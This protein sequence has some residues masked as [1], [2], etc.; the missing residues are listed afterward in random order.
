V[1]LEATFRE[2][3]VS[4]HQLHD[5]LDALNVTLGD[6]PEAGG[7]ALADGFE[8]IVLDL[9]GALHQG[10]R[11]ALH[12]RRAVTPP[13]DIERARRS[14][15]NCQDRFHQIEQ[16]FAANLASYEKLT[17]LARLGTERGEQWRL[18]ANS[19]KLGIEQ[20]Q[21]CLH[22]ASKALAG[23]WKELVEHGGKTSI[24]IRTENLGQKIFAQPKDM[25]G[26]SST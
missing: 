1:A 11:A 13:M 10:R 16:E 7:S 12:A 17:E 4:L 9:I 19:V 2:L 23:G 22:E 26:S 20:C 6:E 5:A 8:N 14:L 15:A 24:S 18:W 21:P 25:V 3:S